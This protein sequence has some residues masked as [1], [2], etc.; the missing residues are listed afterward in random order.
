MFIEQSLLNSGLDKVS[1]KALAKSACTNLARPGT[2][3]I[4]SAGGK[5]TGKIIDKVTR[6]KTKRDRVLSQ[7]LAIMNKRFRN[8]N[9]SLRKGAT[10]SKIMS[11]AQK[12]TTKRM[13]K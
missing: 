11:M 1:A 10:Q 8:K 2:E 7:E 5:L 6:K 4:G 9:G 13:R 3:A 12:A